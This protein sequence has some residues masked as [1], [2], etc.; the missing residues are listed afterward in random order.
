VKA[1]AVGSCC[2]V[3]TQGTGPD[4]VLMHGWGLH[5]GVFDTLAATLA[6]RFRV[7][8][9]DLPGH[10][11]SA[12]CVLV[13]DVDIVTAQ[14]SAA[15]PTPAVWVGW[16]L[17]GLIALQLALRLPAA[18]SAL[19]LVATSPRF[20]RGTDW[21]HGVDDAVLQ[22]FARDLDQDYA[23][24]LARFLAL[25]VRG[26]AQAG[27]TLRALRTRLLEQGAPTPAALH[28]GLDLLRTTDLR[29]QLGGIDCPTHFV[30]GERDVLAPASIAKALR[31]LM[32]AARSSIIHGAGHAPFLSHGAEFIDLL[33][34]FLRD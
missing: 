31:V 34:T 8:R 6:L 32:P 30:F 33:E 27:T 1:R 18:V 4:L 24:T 23:A 3:E 15:L 28:V 16:S 26:S 5:G 22:Q 25:Q 2:F 17:G 7:T 13:N 11:R 12:A 19:M 20:I 9:V 29:A 14:L 21:P 10:G